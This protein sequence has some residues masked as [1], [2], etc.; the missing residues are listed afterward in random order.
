MITQRAEEPLINK[1]ILKTQTYHDFQRNDN[2]HNGCGRYS[3]C[4]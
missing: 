3:R 1:F 2:P 4:S